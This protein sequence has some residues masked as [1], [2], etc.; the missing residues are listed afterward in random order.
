MAGQVTNFFVR[1]D[2]IPAYANSQQLILPWAGGIN[3]AMMSEIDLDLDG[4]KDLFVFDRTGNKITTY[5]NQ[6]TPNQPDYV[7]APEYIDKFPLLHEWAL[8]RDYNCDGLEDIF[9]YSVAGFSIF[10]NI[11]TVT[12]GL[13]F[14]LV[15]YLVNTDRSPNSTHFIGN[16][17][18]SQI[19][20][21]AIR[22]IDGDNDLDVLTFQSLGNQVEFHRNMSMELFGVCDSIRYEVGSNCWG[23]FTENAV[24]AGV[25]L[26]T[27]C[28]PVPLDK[29]ENEAFM[30]SHTGSCLECINVDNDA[31]QDALVGDVSSNSMVFLRNGGTAAYAIIDSADVYFPSYDTAV[32]QAVFNCGFHL[33]VNND[34]L[35]DLVV[36]PSAQNISDNFSSVLY[37]MNTG[38]NDSVRLQFVQN[39]FLQDEMFDFGEGAYPVFFDYDN[40]GDKDILV[41]NYGY[42]DTLFPYPSKIAL[43]KNTGSA[44][45]P[46][47]TLITRDFAGASSSGIARMAPSFGD[48]DGDGDEDMIVGDQSGLLHFFRKDPGPADNFAL[49]Q[50][51]WMGI[52]VGNFAS[53]QLIDIDRDSLID[54][55]IGEQYAT[56]KY[57][58]NTGT[59]TT[60]VYSLITQQLGDVQ[61]NAPSYFTGYAMPWIY[62]ENNQYVLLVGSERGY[63]YRYDNIDGNLGGTFTLTDSMYVNAF[64]G[65]R[66]GVSTSDLNSD[67]IEDVVIGN[68]A[69]GLVIFYGDV[70]VSIG[71]YVQPVFSLHPNPA[72]EKLVIEL[73]ENSVG[74]HDFFVTD[75]A[76]KIVLHEIISERREVISLTSL[77]TGMYVCSLV[78]CNGSAMNQKLVISR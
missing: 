13:Q 43:L 19:D 50:T 47:F 72:Q 5:R 44:S 77:A 69:G 30:R 1:A 7:S 66:L 10:K 23:E 64:E 3:F 42:Y 31:D 58:R 51:N 17:Y 56:L 74:M 57:Y 4:I 35:K 18:V 37:Y 60:P 65:S 14:V 75:L 39:N 46:T 38:T 59:S 6:G 34:G 16:L 55:V 26:N 61:V 49:A 54:L 24:S 40:D 15:K 76:G 67:G 63:V 2:S 25:T 29:T 53:P 41:G 9:T 33:D 73:Q 8:L 27:T 52:D 45:L 70:S 22:D 68:Y 28:A 20:L 48:V 21:P 78:S 71:N 36:C 62:K 12:T 32:D 11:S